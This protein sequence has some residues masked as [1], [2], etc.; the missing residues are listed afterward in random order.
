MYFLTKIAAFFF[1]NLSRSLKPSASEKMKNKQT[2][3]S[4]LF[5]V[6]ILSLKKMFKAQYL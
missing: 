1:F 6:K 2:Q 3:Y 5:Q 4:M